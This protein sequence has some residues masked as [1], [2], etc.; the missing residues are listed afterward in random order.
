MNAASSTGAGAEPRRVAMVTG[1]SSGLGATYADRLAARGYDL[2]LVARRRERLEAA[3]QNIADKTGARIEIITADLAEPAGLLRIETVLSERDDID[4][5]VNN[6]GL[7][8]LGPITKMPADA[9]QNL[10]AVNVIALTRL[11][12]AVLPGFVRRNSGTLINI[13]SMVAVMPT[14]GGAVYS[15]SKGYVLNFTRSLQAELAKTGL[16]IQAVLPGPVHTEFFE[17]QGFTKAPFPAELFMTADDVVD[18]ALAALDAGEPVCLP[19]LRDSS[20][21]KRFEEGRATL[22]SALMK[23]LR[24]PATDR[25]DGTA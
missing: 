6:A 1:A 8:V 9:L 22:S 5:L 18:V 13:S 21:W 3:A 11:S 16:R 2:I 7:G 10:I 20:P 17:T 19:S 24:P 4:V 12:H 15:G 23:P 25:P 14:P